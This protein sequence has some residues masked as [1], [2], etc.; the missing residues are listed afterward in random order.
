MVPSSTNAPALTYMGG[1]QVTPFPMWT[2]S[3]IEE[4]PGTTLTPSS[5]VSRFNGKVCLS[6]KRKL[7]S[8]EKFFKLPILKPSKIPCLTQ[9]LT[10]QAPSR[11]AAARTLPLL[12][13]SLNSS[14]IRKSSREY[15]SWGGFRK[16][17]VISC[18]SSV[19]GVHT[20]GAI[21][22][23]HEPKFPEN[24]GKLGPRPFGD[25]YQRQPVD[26]ADFSHHGKRRLHRYGTGLDKVDLHQRI[27]FSVPCASLL[28]APVQACGGELRHHA[29]RL[30]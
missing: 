2:P 1:M 21:V 17:R 25:R 6:K 29:R 11:F 3:R 19:T 14:K 15:P 30:V 5:M 23:L 9:R 4:P 24:C 18:S 27:K 16:R 8:T 22:S 26:L 28:P 13:A 12:S 20:D 7:S 10:V